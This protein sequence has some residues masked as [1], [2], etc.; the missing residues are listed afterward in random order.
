MEQLIFKT[1]GED[2]ACF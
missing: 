2:N 1:L